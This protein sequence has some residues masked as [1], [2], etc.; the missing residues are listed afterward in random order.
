M[1]AARKK[2]KKRGYNVRRTKSRYFC[3]VVWANGRLIPWFWGGLLK[4]GPSSQA[5]FFM[6]EDAAG[7]E[8]RQI[9]EHPPECG[10]FHAQVVDVAKFN[11]KHGLAIAPQPELLRY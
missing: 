10:N 1:A 11:R 2:A 5:V 9:R 7:S 3:I 4:W 6:D 8:S